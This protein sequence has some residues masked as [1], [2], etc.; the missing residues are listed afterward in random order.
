MNA[1]RFD[2]TATDGTPIAVWVEGRGPAIVMVHGSIADHT[3]FDS[4]AAVLGEQFTTYAM[5]RRGFGATPDID[6]YTIELDFADVAAVVDAVAER[7]RAPVVLWGHSYGANCAI[8]GA[9]RSANV[10]HLVVYEPS[11]GLPYPTGSID[12]IEAALADGD[13]DAAI[14]TVLVEI[15]EMTV[16]DVH[17]LRADPLWPVRLAA[18][19]TVPRECRV[20][21]DWT[22]RPGQFDTVT[23]PTL[24]L[25][26]SDSV[27]DIVHATQ[28]AAAAI[29]R[30][31]IHVLDGHGHFAHKTDPTMV[32][33]VVRDFVAS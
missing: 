10:S 27:T 3:T 25:T 24:L 13:H 12:R 7:T 31:R 28:R 17:T 29:P 33:A 6:D 15:L 5:D 2:V 8:G 22:Y 20:E 32:T 14:V 4:F 21:R 19:P 1:S 23:A 11:L 9:A 16:D 30:G 18:A 26:G